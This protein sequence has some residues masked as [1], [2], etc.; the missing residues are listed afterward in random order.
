[1]K[2]LEYAG[3]GAAAVL[4]RLVPYAS[5]RDQQTGFLFGNPGELAAVL[6]RLIQEPELRQGLRERAHAY[7]E[8]ERLQHQHI[9]KRL[10]F[11]AELSPELSYSGSET[12]P[13]ALFE[14]LAALEGAEARGR[15]LLLAH[16][17]YETLLHDGLLRLQAGDEAGAQMLRQAAEL[18]PAQ[19]L[20]QL[21]L[22]SCTNSEAE[23]AAALAKN[24]RSVQAALG[25]GTELLKRGQFRAAF[26]RFLSAAELC[27]AYEMPYAHAA[28][29]LRRIGA[30]REAA[31]L[32]L[33][34]RN[35]AAQVAPSA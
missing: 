20:P 11:Y 7:V 16:G 13:R 6:T 2:F 21:L 10:D 23:L 3:F 8:A 34:A 24:P 5:V 12:D 33:L 4:R 22:G 27:P 1:V 29:A 26:E 28:E 19:A 9:G 32:E 25:L 15:H 30:E 18:E 14:E 31:E 17:R 35:L